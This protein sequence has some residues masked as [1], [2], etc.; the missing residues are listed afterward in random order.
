MAEEFF[1]SGTLSGYSMKENPKNYFFVKDIRP[2]ARFIVNGEKWM[3][4]NGKDLKRSCSD[5]EQKIN[6]TL[7]A[8]GKLDTEMSEQETSEQETSNII[9]LSS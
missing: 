7:K 9:S 2:V 1:R 3:L 4:F 5:M 6:Q 8:L